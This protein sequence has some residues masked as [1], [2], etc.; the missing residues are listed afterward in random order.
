MSYYKEPS[1]LPMPQRKLEFI[2]PLAFSLLLPWAQAADA[3]QRSP[4]QVLLVVNANSPISQA[5]AD[6]YAL[7]RNI[8]NVL[9][10]QCQD[11]A[12]STKNETIALADYTG[13]IETPIHAYLATHTNID[14]VV[15]TKGIPIR[16][17]GSAMGSCDEPSRGPAA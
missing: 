8:K 5:I 15:L 11:S 9:S 4:G 10:I 17:T 13:F 7:K 12:V 6:D 3:T 14:F 2:L 16:I 1:R